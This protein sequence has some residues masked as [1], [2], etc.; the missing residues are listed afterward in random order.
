M[1]GYFQGFKSNIHFSCI[2]YHKKPKKS[3][4]ENKQK[5]LFRVEQTRIIDP[6]HTLVMESRDIEKTT[7]PHNIL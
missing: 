6:G 5:D 3:S 1:I 4:N 7:P 2:I